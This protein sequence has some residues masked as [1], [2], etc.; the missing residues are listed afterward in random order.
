MI[1]GA[2]FASCNIISNITHFGHEGCP[3]N[4]NLKANKFVILFFF[5]LACIYALILFACFKKPF[6][7]LT[8]TTT[9]SFSSSSL[10]TLFFFFFFCNSQGW[11]GSLVER[12]LRTWKTTVRIPPFTIIKKPSSFI[13]RCGK[14][15][16]STNL[17]FNWHSC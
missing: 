5:F 4:R 9:K 14:Q 3:R 11:Q 15:V 10:P 2:K 16:R 17:H 1:N 6:S 8:S 7:Y 12:H 13:Y